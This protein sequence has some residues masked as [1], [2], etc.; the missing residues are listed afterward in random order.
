[1]MLPRKA[2]DPEI[3]AVLLYF[4]LLLLLLH[5]ASM[6]QIQDSMSEQ[7]CGDG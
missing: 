3:T 4:V 7:C 6:L 2:R 1:M 5:L